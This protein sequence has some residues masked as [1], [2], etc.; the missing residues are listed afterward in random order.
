MFSKGP[1][2]WATMNEG[3]K[4]CFWVLSDLHAMS[5]KSEMLGK[6]P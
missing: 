1:F 6:D 5:P 2:P 3:A 4:A